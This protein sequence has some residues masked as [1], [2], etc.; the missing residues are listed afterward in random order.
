MMIRTAEYSDAADLAAI[1][2]E[3]IALGGTTAHLTPV[4]GPIIRQ[5]MDHDPEASSWVLAEQDG[6]VIGFQFAEPHSQLPPEAADI[7]SF[8][9]PGITGKGTGRALFTATR[10]ACRNLGYKWIN[11]TIRADNQSGLTYYSAMGFKDWHI[12][13]AAELSD[14]RITGKISKRFDL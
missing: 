7:A 10:D 2:N 1:L 5:W 6:A 9:K 3:I 4:S 8:V 13:P 14:G 12:D 11:A